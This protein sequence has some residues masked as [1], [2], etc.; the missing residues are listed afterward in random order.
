MTGSAQSRPGGVASSPTPGQ[1]TGV[2][3][4]AKSSGLLEVNVG[5]VLRTVRAAR[6]VTYAAG[7]VVLVHRFGQLW[8]AS[9][10]LGT[11]A[12]TEMPPTF[13]DLDPNPTVVTGD[14]TVLAESTG[15]YRAG[16]WSIND[17]VRQGEYWDYG[18]NTGAVFYGTK[19]RSLTGATVTSARLE[20]IARIRGDHASLGSTL[21]LITE[22]TR[23]AGAPT[24]TSSTAGPSTVRDDFPISFTI[25]TAWAQAIVDGTSGGIGFYDA[26]GVP[27][28]EFAGRSI[29][30]T[31]F[32]LV[33]DWSR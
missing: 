16:G 6:D 29:D 32:T 10:R 26:D 23:P 5:G 30:P 4:G 21:R 28:L 14:L 3:T 31:A 18:L 15:T 13:T 25:P 1:F 12:V 20:R 22:S 17:S 33:I 8:A 11:A 19:A 24:L 9:A 27:F 2:A 7:D